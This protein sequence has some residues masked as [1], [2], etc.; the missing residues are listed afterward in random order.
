MASILSHLMKSD[1]TAVKRRKFTEGTLRHNLYKKAR[2]TLHEGMN[3]KQG[4]KLPPDE[5]FNDWLAVHVVDFFNRI[6]VLYGVVADVCTEASCPIMSGGSQYEYFW[7][8][9]QEFKKPTALSAP[10]YHLRLFQWVEKQIFDESIFPPDTDSDFPKNF[11]KTCQKILNRMF[12]VFVHVYIHHFDR[13]MEINA[14]PH[15]NTLF[16]HFY[17]FVTEFQLMDEKA[18]APLALLIDKICN[19]P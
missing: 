7:L 13:L 18:F 5:T 8:D 10:E 19:D 6:Q 9:G 3:L 17:Y 14:E 4:V 1:G 15:G 2:E 11:K 16:K 12:R